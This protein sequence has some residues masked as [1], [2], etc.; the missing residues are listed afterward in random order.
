MCQAVQQGGGHPFA[1]KDLAPVAEGQIACDQQAAAFVAIGEHLE[2][3][4][5]AAATE[6]E[7][8]QFINDQQIRAV[9]LS[10]QAVD[11]VRL[12][13]RFEQVHQSGGCEEAD[14]VSLAARGG[15]E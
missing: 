5:R 3:Q 11:L 9:Q 8:T 10:Q 6:R 7:I 2:Q 15:R 14:A 1:L 12:L 13:F 4:F